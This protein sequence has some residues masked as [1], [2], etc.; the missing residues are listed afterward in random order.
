VREVAG[1]PSR[2]TTRAPYGWA[3]LCSAALTIVT[4]PGC[5]L[6][7]DLDRGVALGEADAS[8]DARAG[9]VSREA[10][11]EPV[12]AAGDP[13]VA[14]DAFASD[15]SPQGNESSLRDGAADTS[16]TECTPD[17]SWCDSHCGTGPDNC[18]Q[19]RACASDCAQGYACGASNTCECQ[20]EITWCSGRCGATTDN[21][22]R[23]IDC[24]PCDASVCDAEP[25]T[26]ACGSRQ[27]GQTVNN[28]HQTVNCGLLGLG[29]CAQPLQQACLSDGGCCSPKSSAACGNQCG[30]FATDNCGRQV[31]CP[32][33][34]GS[35]R[36]CAQQ[37]C[38]TPVDPCNGACGVTMTNNCGQTVQC[39]CTGAA[40]CAATT[41]KCCAPQGCS[42][43]CVDSCGLPA[44]SC[45]IDAGVD[46]AV[47]AGAADSGASEGGPG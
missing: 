45:C 4:V 20:R 21:C 29:L 30:T 24:G 16:P 6:I 11:A 1:S 2:W 15:D 34:C 25:D 38:C 12:D 7:L 9:D 19:S 47:E 40:E 8:L 5:G 46:A 26:A 14:Y 18:G 32:S 31:Q 36:V 28:C 13:R 27:C 17:P 23:P 43:N 44:A 10:G 37:A 3:R 39:S 42:A 41:G 35:G 33:S 22:L